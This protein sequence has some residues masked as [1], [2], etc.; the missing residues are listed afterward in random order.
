MP[1]YK[2][3]TNLT[4]QSALQTQQL[5]G[6]AL[7]LFYRAEN[8]RPMT[9]FSCIANLQNKRNCWFVSG[10]YHFNHISQFIA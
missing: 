4:D 3:I 9:W 10:I 7:L 1:I 5:L 2:I 8:N 6:L